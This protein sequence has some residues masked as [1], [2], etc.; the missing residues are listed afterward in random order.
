MNIEEIK[1][2]PTVYENI[3]ESIF[4]SFHVLEKVKTMLQRNDSK[5]TILEMIDLFYTKNGLDLSVLQN[6]LDNAL[7]NE[8]KESLIQF[9]DSKRNTY[10]YE[11]NEEGDE[12]WFD[13][14]GNVRKKIIYRNN[15]TKWFEVFFNE[16]GNLHNEDGYA[17]QSWRD[18]G[19]I[20]VQEYWLKNKKL[21][22]QEWKKKTGRK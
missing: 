5:E 14:N 3:S 6:K 21:S 13:Q 18:N 10:R 4:K 12:F 19:E 8:T 17:Y 11:K 15:G 7:V 22:E 20:S 9:I 16:N 1:K 2:L